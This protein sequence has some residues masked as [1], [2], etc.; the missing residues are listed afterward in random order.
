MIVSPLLPSSPPPLSPSVISSIHPLSR[1][2][3]PPEF[4]PIF[5]LNVFAKIH[6][7]SEW[8]VAILRPSLGR[9][10]EWRFWSDSMD[11]FLIDNS[12]DD[13]IFSDDGRYLFRDPP[14]ACGTWYD[15]FVPKRIK[16]NEIKRWQTGALRLFIHNVFGHRFQPIKHS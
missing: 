6:S 4:S 9:E 2:T 13:C 14:P 3:T 8:L 10:G 12:G 15:F 1:G 7:K 11:W 5:P 16:S